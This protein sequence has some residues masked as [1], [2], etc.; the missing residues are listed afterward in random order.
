L[1]K[2]TNVSEE[3]AEIEAASA[4][5]TLVTLNQACCTLKMEAASASETLVTLNQACCT[6][7]MEA[8]GASETL[9]TFYQTTW[10]HIPEDIKHHLP[11]FTFFF[12]CHETE[13]MKS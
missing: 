11:V 5:E 13:R 4:S 3:R 2:V 8:A 7:K 6:L 1:L 9:L 10:G 12:S